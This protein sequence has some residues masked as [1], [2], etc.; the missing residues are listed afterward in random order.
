MHVCV[1]VCMYA[2]MHVCVYVCMCMCVIVTMCV[3]MFVC[4][5]ILFLISTMST[6]MSVAVMDAHQVDGVYVCKCRGV[7]NAN[8]NVCIG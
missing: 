3:C 7:G 5:Y 8:G 1:C 4:V 6:W 2:C